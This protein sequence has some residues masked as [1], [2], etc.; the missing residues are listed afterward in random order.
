MKRIRIIFIIVSIIISLIIIYAIINGLISYKYEIEGRIGDK[1]DI[2]WV[3][4]LLLEKI[5]LLKIYLGYV[6]VTIIYLMISIFC[7]SSRL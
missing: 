7:K 5:T 6:I 4:N 2:Q 3:A 1:V